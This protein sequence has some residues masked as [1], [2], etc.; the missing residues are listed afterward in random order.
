LKRFLSG[1]FIAAMLL[2]SFVA[3]FPTAASASSPVKHVIVIMEENF[4]ITQVIGDKIHA[5]YMNA[6]GAKYS[7]AAEYSG[8]ACCQSLSKYV[9]ITSG[10][11][12]NCDLGICWNYPS[13]VKAGNMNYKN[14]GDLTSWKLYAESMPYACDPNDYTPTGFPYPLYIA[15]H[16]PF[17]LY[18]DVWKNPT[19]C[20]SLDV[21]FES[22][23]TG[24]LHDLNNGQLPAFSFIVPNGCDDGHNFVS[25][26]V[27]WC[28]ASPDKC[29]NVSQLT[30]TDQW[31][32]WLVPK[33]QASP[34]WS[35][36]ALLITY[37]DEGNQAYS[38]GYPQNVYT[39]WASPYTRMGYVS[40]IAYNHYSALATFERLLGLGSLGAGDATAT[41][42]LD[43]FMRSPPTTTATSTTGISTT[44][45]ATTTTRP[46]TTTA[47]SV[48]TI[49]HS[50]TST[51]TAPARR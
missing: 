44:S 13:G 15:G 3:F 42:M 1:V 32:A 10:L 26:C 30:N 31:L 17:V 35:S 36:T 20:N 27:P 9:A 18:T 39:V 46:A 4:S 22:S 23:T 11:L 41:P 28:P 33:I 51:T 16:N 19:L 50:T 5:P 45:T 8:M 40:S 37:D 25:N 49:S 48:T 12:P 21:P 2:G 24:F 29:T 14:I 6:L 47:T 38:A 43:M 7:L 34:S